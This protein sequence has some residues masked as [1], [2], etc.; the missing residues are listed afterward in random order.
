MSREMRLKETILLRRRVLFEKNSF[1]GSHEI[2]TKPRTTSSL[3]LCF[4]IL[5]FVHTSHC[6]RNIFSSSIGERQHYN[7]CFLLLHRC[8]FCVRLQYSSS[9]PSSSSSPRLFSFWMDDAMMIKPLFMLSCFHLK[10]L[11]A[12]ITFSVWRC[13]L[14]FLSLLSLPFHLVSFRLACCLNI[15]NNKKHIFSHHHHLPIRSR[16]SACP[17]EA[18]Y[19]LAWWSCV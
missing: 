14:F 12:L 3:F 9:P 8:Y 5:F 19:T 1:T 13:L 10:Y 7:S 17:S 18:V 6:A 11:F 2:Q 15:H 4:S 16:C